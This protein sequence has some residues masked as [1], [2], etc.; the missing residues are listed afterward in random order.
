MAADEL[1]WAAESGNLGTYPDVL[2]DCAVDEESEPSQVTIFDPQA[3][4]IATAWITADYESGVALD[5]V[6]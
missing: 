6:P 3:E 1:K 4:D 5:Q 2:L